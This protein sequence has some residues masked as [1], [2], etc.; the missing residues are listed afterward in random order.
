MFGKSRQESEP[1]AAPWKA[2]GGMP[3]RDPAPAP[4][5]DRSLVS[6]L[7]EPAI[8]PSIVSDAVVFVGDIASKGALHIDGSAK[9]TVTAD[10]VT[11]G[12][13]GELEGEV[14]CRKLHVKGRVNGSVICEELI[15][16]DAARVDG[17]MSY[18][19]I[20][21]HRGARVAGE[22]SIVE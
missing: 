4:V 16:A 3:G 7:E 8:K 5:A 10:S 20:Q 13:G 6:G 17:S 21:M 22:M 9:G 2:L 14:R 18:R 15:V 1:K 19:T 12:P 11:V